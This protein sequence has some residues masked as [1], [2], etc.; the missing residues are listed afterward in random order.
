MEDQSFEISGVFHEQVAD[1]LPIVEL[2]DWLNL[3][4]ALSSYGSGVQHLFL[5]F[6]AVPQE[7]SKLHN[8]IRYD[9]ETALLQ[10]SLRLPYEPL[11]DSTP[12]KARLL[13]LESFLA[14][15]ESMVPELEIEG[16][17]WEEL[18]G[19]LRGALS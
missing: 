7:E 1:K 8:D 18:L 14:A 13:M 9:S 10:I 12:A 17:D 16:F 4:F 11:L 2:E 5:L 3:H 6:M 19:D 15:L